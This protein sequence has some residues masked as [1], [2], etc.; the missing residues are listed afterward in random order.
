M[1]VDVEER[2]AELGRRLAGGDFAVLRSYL[3][4]EYYRARP[5]PGEPAACERIADLALALRAAMPDL[6]AALDDV[7]IGDDVITD[8]GH[9]VPDHRRVR[10]IRHERLHSGP[11]SRVGAQLLSARPSNVY[12][13]GLGAPLA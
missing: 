6:S 1:V 3:A 5:G 9:L 13:H 2:L 11:G 4:D 10:C 7:T 8:L 12:P